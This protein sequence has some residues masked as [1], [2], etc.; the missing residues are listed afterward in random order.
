MTLRIIIYILNFEF[1]YEVV[2]LFQ[3][4]INF[5]VT[6]LQFN[7][8]IFFRWFSLSDG[9]SRD[10]MSRFW[11]I[12]W[13]L[14]FTRVCNNKTSFY[15][16]LT[17]PYTRWIFWFTSVCFEESFDVLTFFSIFKNLRIWINDIWQLLTT[18]AKYLWSMLWVN[19]LWY[20]CFNSEFLVSLKHLILLLVSIFVWKLL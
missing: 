12:S 15:N 11:S 14:R 9:T 4:H 10:S 20:S 18:I 6:R 17:F 3:F 2:L 1:H 19:I 7:F 16:F 5:T 13:R 8:E